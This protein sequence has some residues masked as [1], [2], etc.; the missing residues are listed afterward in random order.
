MNAIGR[1]T[2]GR[3]IIPV[4]NGRGISIMRGFKFWLAGLDWTPQLA[5]RPRKRGTHHS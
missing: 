2:T 4:L 5:E 1:A 3:G